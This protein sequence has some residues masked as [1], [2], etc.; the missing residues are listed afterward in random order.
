MKKEIFTSKW[1]SY[2]P[3]TPNNRGTKSTKRPSGTFGTGISDRPPTK[4]DLLAQLRIGQAWLLDQ[5]HRWQLGDS[6]AVD[7]VEFSRT[8]N[9]WWELDHRLR[10]DYGFQGCIYVP[11]GVCPDGFPCRGCADLPPTT[12][13]AQ[14]EL[15][16]G[17]GLGQ[18]NSHT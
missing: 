17:T 1:L 15:T 13:V 2:S 14:L 6:T 16:T 3:K 18:N 11:D 5:H 9:G 7:D 8:W 4:H 12:M 10:E